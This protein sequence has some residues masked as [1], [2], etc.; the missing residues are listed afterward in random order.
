MS[1]FSQS[2]GTLPE[3]HAFT[4]MKE[5]G[6][7]I[8]STSSSR[9]FPFFSLFSFL[10]DSMILSLLFTFSLSFPFLYFSWLPLDIF[11]LTV[12]LSYFSLRVTVALSLVTGGKTATLC[13]LPYSTAELSMSFK[14][15]DCP[16]QN[17]PFFL[18]IKHFTP[19]V[20]VVIAE[21]IAAW[22]NC[23]CCLWLAL[24]LQLFSSWRVP[25]SSRRP[26]IHVR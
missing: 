3:S 11:F 14:Q 4:D 18:C 19:E 7:A 26:S 15:S 8:T 17:D 1:P 6:L 24:Y 16:E 21:K 20:E 2:Q 25:F 12:F 22:F 9:T 5:R 13:S 23:F 10:N